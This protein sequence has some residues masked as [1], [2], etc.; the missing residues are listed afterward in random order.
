MAEYYS[1][2]FRGLE[3][4]MQFLANQ[5]RTA[6]LRQGVQT[7]ADTDRYRVDSKMLDARNARQE[8]ARQFDV[9]SGQQQLAIDNDFE[10]MMRELDISDTE[11]QSQSRLRDAQGET[12]LASAADT[13]DKTGARQ[14]ARENAAAAKVRAQIDAEIMDRFNGDAKAAFADPDFARRTRAMA[15]DVLGRSPS[16]KG[17]INRNTRM[18]VTE[19]NPLREIDGSGVYAMAGTSDINGQETVATARG[20]EVRAGGTDG[21]L[22]LD[23]QEILAV[24]DAKAYQNGYQSEFTLNNLAA[25][26]ET[27]GVT[28]EELADPD[29]VIQ[30][31]QRNTG[32]APSDEEVQG[33]RPPLQAAGNAAPQTPAAPAPE[34]PAGPSAFR[35]QL[36]GMNAVHGSNPDRLTDFVQGRGMNADEASFRRGEVTADNGSQRAMAE[37]TVETRNDISLAEANADIN[38]P[39]RDL[40]ARQER[41]SLLSK[42]RAAQVDTAIETAIAEVDLSNSSEVFDQYFESMRP[43]DEPQNRDVLTREVKLAFRQPE[44]VAKLESALGPM[45]NWDSMDYKTATDIILLG[46][47]YDHIP[48]WIGRWMPNAVGNAPK[49]NSGKGVTEE[50]IQRWRE[51]ESILT[52]NEGISRPFNK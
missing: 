5:E 32:D 12:Y 35:R 29:N 44:S 27:L 50:G 19:G 45:S 39:N 4:G 6:A 42:E 14:T 31:L 20:G 9:T 47:K 15:S 21:A 28:P 11:V 26:S 16:F 38:A 37:D 40:R 52:R 36:T 48:K 13:R 1:S 24:L 2:G 43:G 33:A 22:N 17:A 7:R 25:A 46:R 41:S 23:A 18:T 49:D 30:Y 3:A 51:G 10:A 8:Q 34:Q